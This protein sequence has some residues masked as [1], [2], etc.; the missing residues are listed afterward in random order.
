MSDRLRVGIAGF[1]V[2][3]RRRRQCIDANPHLRTV[4]VSDV[5]FGGSGDAPDGVGYFASYEGLF[6]EAL[7]ALFVCLPNYLAPEATM[8]GLERGLHVFCEKPPGRTVDDIRRVIAVE[9]R[10]PGRRLKYGFNHR[11]HESVKEAKRII[12]SGRF[13]RVINLRGVYGKSRIIPFSGGWRSERRLAGGGILMDQ[14]IH[15]L[16]M[17]R[18]FAGDFD[19][20]KSFVSN[21]YW[22]HDVEDNAYVLMRNRGGCVAMLH[23]TATQWRHKFRLE[24]TL[25]KGL[26][27]LT[28]ILSGSKSYGE[29]RLTIVPRDEDSVVGCFQET[30]TAYLEDTS[31]QEE[32]DEFAELIAHGGEVVNGGSQDALKVMELVYRIY[33]AD[34]Q[35][36]E[37]FG[38]PDPDRPADGDR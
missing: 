26:L 1:G 20:V 19:E 13:G 35:W 31:W 15:M 12:D 23:S 8:A 34:D 28:G 21:G 18:Y 14:G 25:E 33:D 7:D 5:T 10:H 9:R 38:I 29:E 24:I 2:V 36:R 6:D 3:G 37:A 30:T 11:Y 32:V 16:D 4:A 17:I 22:H 27:E